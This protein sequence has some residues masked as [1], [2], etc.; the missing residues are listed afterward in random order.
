MRPVDEVMRIY[1][2]EPLDEVTRYNIERFLQK[3]YP[4]AIWKVTLGLN[5]DINVRFK[6]PE[7]ETFY[8]LK[9]T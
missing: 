1:Q 3:E 5:L 7:D 6:S 9:W 4:E 8:R 2:F